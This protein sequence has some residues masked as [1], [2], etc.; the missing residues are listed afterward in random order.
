MAAPQNVFDS[1]PKDY[2]ASDQM[3][4]FEKEKNYWIQNLTN[5][6]G[7][8]ITKTVCGKYV[9][10]LLFFILFTLFIYFNTRM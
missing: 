10:L 4:N 9:Q 7:E 1:F 6:E 5:R 3:I 8:V 2:K